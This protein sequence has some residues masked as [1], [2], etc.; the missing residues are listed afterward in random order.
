VTFSPRPSHDHC[1]F[2]AAAS[3]LHSASKGLGLVHLWIRR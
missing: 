3:M 2:S 1:D